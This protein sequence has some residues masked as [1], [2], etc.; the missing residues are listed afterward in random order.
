MRVL[1]KEKAILLV[2]GPRH[3]TLIEGDEAVLQAQLFPSVPL[4][5]I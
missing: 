3:H 2:A 4:Y 1:V 5:K